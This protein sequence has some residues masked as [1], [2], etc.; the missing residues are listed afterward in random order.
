MFFRID[1]IKRTRT[2]N[3][4]GIRE[5]MEKENE[6]MVVTYIVSCMLKPNANTIRDR[7]YGD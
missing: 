2:A 1:N 3:Q 7:Y 5:R 6:D 4:Q